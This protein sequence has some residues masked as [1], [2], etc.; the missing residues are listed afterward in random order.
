MYVVLSTNPTLTLLH[1]F[2]VT[3]KFLLPSFPKFALYTHQGNDEFAL[4]EDLGSH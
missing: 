2:L 4:E 1:V 3:K